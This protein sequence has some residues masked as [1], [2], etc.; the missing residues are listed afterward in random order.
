[1]K[2]KFMAASKRSS[3][4]PKAAL[5]VRVA[6]LE[7]TVLCLVKALILTGAARPRRK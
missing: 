7:Q 1:M 4:P 3:K 6:A 5:E 2:G